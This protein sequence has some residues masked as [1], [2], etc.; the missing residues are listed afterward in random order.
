MSNLSI[1]FFGTRGSIP[2]CGPQVA[3]FGGNTT[4][5][6]FHRKKTG[7]ISIM[8]AGTGIRNLGKHINKKYPDQKQLNITFSHFHWDHIQ[9]FP[10]FDP[11]YNPEMTIDILVY[12]REMG[13]RKVKEIFANQMMEDYFPV[14]LDRMGA[15]F[16]FISTHKHYY[17]QDGVRLQAINQNH[18]GGSLGFRVDVDGASFAIMT[19]HEHGDQVEQKYVEF[20]KD[21]DVL[22]HDA[23]YTD[24]ELQIHKGWGHSSYEQCIELAERANVKQLIF[25]HHDPDHDDD[26]LRKMENK[27]QDRF[28]NCLMAREG[29]DINI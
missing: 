4:C 25:T 12:G 20:V 3:E 7:L 29:M 23:Q 19:D 5:I 2:I 18:P 22:I 8:D 1:T 13:D 6:A 16:N 14:P 9:G 27:Y 26:F 17:E 10:F 15:A 11:A 21:V 28:P 24:E